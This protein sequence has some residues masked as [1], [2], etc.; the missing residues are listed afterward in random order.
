MSH[1][2][3]HL[4]L[5]PGLLN[6][7][8]LWRGPISGLAGIAEMSV[9]DLTGAESMRE[10][11]AAVLARA[12]VRFALAGLSM[13]GYVALEIMRQAPGRVTA[14]ALL[15]TSARPDTREATEGRRTLME[16][17]KTDFPSVI[18]TM[19]PKL[20]HP[21]HVKDSAIA[22]TF[23]AMARD[24]GQRAYLQQQTAIM[25]RIDSRPFLRRIACP[26]LV[27][28]GRDDAVTP[29]EIHEEMA[30]EIPGARLEIIDHC[31]HLSALERPEEVLDHLKKWLARTAA[32]W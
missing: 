11:A 12:P 17:S 7:A 23:R 31:G 32:S 18:E 13:G 20:V 16:R 29:P 15:D 24:V 26:T 27:L 3:P 30:S 25:N 8:R 28:C 1:A 2:F 22:D 5:L 14:L 10:L 6:D 9:G 4:V 21:D 19:L